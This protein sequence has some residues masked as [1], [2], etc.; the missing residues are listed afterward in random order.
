MLIFIIV[1]G[2]FVIGGSLV[3]AADLM[4]NKSRR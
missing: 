4:S 2:A 1:T 3:L